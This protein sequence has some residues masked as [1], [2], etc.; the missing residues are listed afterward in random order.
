MRTTGARGQLCSSAT[1]LPTK[2]NTQWSGNFH[3]W[4]TSLQVVFCQSRLTLGKFLQKYRYRKDQTTE[5]FASWCSDAFLFTFLAA[6]NEAL[7]ETWVLLIPISS[8]SLFT[9]LNLNR[10]PGICVMLKQLKHEDPKEEQC[11][12]PAETAQALGQARGG[13]GWANTSQQRSLGGSEK[14]GAGGGE[15]ASLARG[16]HGGAHRRS[17]RGP[18]VGARLGWSPKGARPAERRRG[19]RRPAGGGQTRG[20]GPGRWGRRCPF[21]REPLLS[22][23]APRAPGPP[24]PARY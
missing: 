19:R 16:E 10:L 6:R 23:A 2:T 12:S 15:A 22:P 8:R 21:K 4:R 7:R 9:R 13:R 18:A 14:A 11:G 3:C 5:T 20:G 1:F 17:D 24:P